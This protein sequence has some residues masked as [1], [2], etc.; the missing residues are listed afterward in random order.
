MKIMDTLF[1]IGIAATF[2]ALPFFIVSVVQFHRRRR[3]LPTMPRSIVHFPEKSV[4]L[5]VVPIVVVAITATIATSTVRRETLL[6]L[7]QPA[8]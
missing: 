6:F 2:V 7:Q 4:A 5:L 1:Y 8:D 3:A